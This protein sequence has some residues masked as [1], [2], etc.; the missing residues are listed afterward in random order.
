MAFSWLLY[1]ELGTLNLGRPSDEARDCT[2]QAGQGL[3]RGRFIKAEARRH[4][5]DG[6]IIW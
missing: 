5:T 4:S 6:C 3:A 2:A 1:P